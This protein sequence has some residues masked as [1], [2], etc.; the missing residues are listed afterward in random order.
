MITQAFAEILRQ[1]RLRAGY[2][3]EEFGFR[4]ELHRTYISQLERGIKTPTI[5]TA[6]RIATAW[7]YRL[8]S[9]WNVLN[10]ELSRMRLSLRQQKLTPAVANEFTLHQ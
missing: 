4:T 3:Q 9:L 8:Q 5:E 2:S 1:E 10:N 7:D 6:Y